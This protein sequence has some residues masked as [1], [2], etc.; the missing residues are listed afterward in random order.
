MR[1]IGLGSGGQAQGLSLAIGGDPVSAGRLGGVKRPVGAV[2]ERVEVVELGRG[3]TRVYRPETRPTASSV[4]SSG[5]SCQARPGS[6][7]IAAASVA[8]TPIDVANTSAR[9]PERAA[10]PTR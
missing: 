3:V 10:Q 2:K 7:M 1:L 9:L 8:E 5:R 6:G 4:T